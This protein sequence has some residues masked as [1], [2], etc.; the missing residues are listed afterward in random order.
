[1]NFESAW[2]TLITGLACTIAVVTYLRRLGLWWVFGSVG[3]AGHVWAHLTA[4]AHAREAANVGRLIGLFAVP[5]I[6][7]FLVVAMAVLRPERT[8]VGR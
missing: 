1:M 3:A 4:L 2:H 5:M 7:A 6:W 8:D